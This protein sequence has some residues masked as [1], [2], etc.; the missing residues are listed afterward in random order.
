M[1]GEEIFLNLYFVLRGAKPVNLKKQFAEFC[2]IVVLNNDYIKKLQQNYFE[3]YFFHKNSKEKFFLVC[4]PWGC[5]FNNSF[6]K[7]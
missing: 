7:F 5:I 6:V 2:A 3:L 1:I 4:I